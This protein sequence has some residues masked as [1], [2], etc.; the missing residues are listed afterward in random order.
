MLIC[1]LEKIGIAGTKSLSRKPKRKER[2][3]DQKKNFYTMHLSQNLKINKTLKNSRLEM[4][5]AS[6]N[7]R[8]RRKRV[9][10]AKNK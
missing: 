9:Q 5:S 10:K 1:Y 7:Q 6:T 3:K 8:G 2:E 4:T